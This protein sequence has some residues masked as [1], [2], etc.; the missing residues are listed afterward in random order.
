[1]KTITFQ[2]YPYGPVYSCEDCLVNRWIIKVLSMRQKLLRMNRGNPTIDVARATGKLIGEFCALSR[3]RRSSLL[4]LH[5]NK[6]LFSKIIPSSPTLRGFFL[7]FLKLIEEAEIEIAKT[8][9]REQN[10][11]YDEVF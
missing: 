4:W 8:A 2:P 6:L 11:S 10:H 5:R 1:M 9:A 3:A 7:Q